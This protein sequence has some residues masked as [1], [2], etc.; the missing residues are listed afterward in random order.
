[1]AIFPF[2]EFI[3]KRF[4]Q[5]LVI[6]AVHLIFLNEVIKAHFYNIDFMHQRLK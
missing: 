1:M 5:S 4:K 6:N 2:R 3:Y